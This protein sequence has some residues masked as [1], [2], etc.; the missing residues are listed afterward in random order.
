MHIAKSYTIKNKIK[1]KLQLF[2]DIGLNFDDF[3]ANN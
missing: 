2:I 3:I 1:P